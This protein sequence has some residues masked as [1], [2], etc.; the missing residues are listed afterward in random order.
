MTS[1]VPVWRPTRTWI[2]PGANASV[3]A[4]RGRERTGSRRE[5]EEERVALGVHLDAALGGARL[6]DQAAVLGERLRVCLCAELVQEL[7]RAL[8]VR[9]EERDGAGREVV[10]HAA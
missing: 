9:E 8:D 6:P 3:I 7:R 2:A 10:A 4:R 1:G 5:G